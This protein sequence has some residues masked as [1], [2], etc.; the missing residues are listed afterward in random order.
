MANP[1]EQLLSKMDDNTASLQRVLQDI[2][3]QA[4]LG[5]M[6]NQLA[7][8]IKRAL[9]RIKPVIDQPVVRL[10]Y[11]FPL[12]QSQTIAAGQTGVPLTT[13]D[14]TNALEWPFEIHRVK[15]SQDASHSARDWRVNITDQT[16]NQPMMKASALVADLIDNNTG[17]WSLGF[18]WIVRPKGGGLTVFADNLDSSNPIIVDINFSGYLLIPRA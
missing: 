14:F 16:F 13:S 18:P 1:V 7:P 6:L 3:R 17:A 15:F 8:T 10:P 4:G 2:Q 11:N 5:A 9:D 12:S